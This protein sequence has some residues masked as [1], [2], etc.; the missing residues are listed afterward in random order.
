M[1]GRVATAASAKPRLRGLSHAAAF[2]V[3]VPLGVL[4]VIAAVACQY[5]AV[6]F[7][8]LPDH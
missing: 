8:V 2:L 4:L 5:S 7:Y 3:A 6:A 1:S